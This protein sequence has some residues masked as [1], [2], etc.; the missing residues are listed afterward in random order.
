MDK[1]Q[2]NHLVL[3]PIQL[4]PEQ[5]WLDWEGD[6][7]IQSA[8]HNLATIVKQILDNYADYYIPATAYVIDLRVKA[9]L[10]K[11][12]ERQSLSLLAYA[13]LYAID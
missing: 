7:I 1:E 3:Q 6:Q 11:S 9:P 2:N 13:Y 5:I 10:C 4:G 8:A 12:S